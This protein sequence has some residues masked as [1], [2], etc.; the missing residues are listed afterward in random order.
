[1]A[2]AGV[3]VSNKTATTSAKISE[4]IEILRVFIFH[5]SLYVRAQDIV[6]SVKLFLSE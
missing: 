6:N 2:K 4:R 5:Y 3:A 1:M